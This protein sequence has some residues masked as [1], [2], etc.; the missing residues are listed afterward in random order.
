MN[1]YLAID[2]GASSGRH[3]LG[4]VE[5]GRIVLEE[6]YRFDNALVKRKG[7]LCWDISLLYEHVLEGLRECYRKGIVPKSLGIDTWGVDFVLLDKQN[8]IVGDTV[9]YRDSR[10]EGIDAVVENKISGR[11]LYSR[12]G[13]QKLPFNT[14]YQLIAIKNQN[15]AW[16]EQTDSLM[17]IPDYFNFLLSGKKYAEYT[18]ASTTALLDVREKKW[19]FELIDMLGLPRS[20]FLPV[21]KPGTSIGSLQQEVQRLVGFNTDI[22]LP[23]THDTGSAFLAVPAVDNKSI[24]ISSGTWSLLGIENMTP[25]VSEAGMSANFT[26]EGGFDYRYRYLKNYMGLWM[27]Q[28]VRREINNK[29]SYAEMED[30]ARKAAGYCE[31]VDV[32]DV[33][34]TAPDSMITAINTVLS[35]DN[36]PLPKNLAETLSCIYNSLSA[37]YADGVTLLKGLAGRNFKRINIVGG[38]SK[39]AYLNELTEKKTGLKVIAGPAE[40]TAIGNLL[41]QMLAGGDFSGITEAREAVAK[42]LKA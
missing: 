17:M 13:I 15:P 3:I 32:N 30:M 39:D 35:R 8:R 37:S 7:H 23:A 22:V 29:Y 40:A 1:T 24:Y 21:K 10:V 41:A 12:T 2:I 5:S 11:E 27:V 33:I 6:I 28:S 18:N 34:F 26:N 36:K 14:I 31:V 9:S 42:T 16:L 19:D 38:G 25:L 4:H 20:V